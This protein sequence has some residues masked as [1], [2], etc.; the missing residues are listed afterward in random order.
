[1]AGNDRKGTPR[2]TE[3]DEFTRRRE[4]GRSA[5]CRDQAANARE[6]DGSLERSRDQER[7]ERDEMVER[8]EEKTGRRR[9]Q[10]PRGGGLAAGERL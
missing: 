5:C 8:A 3:G 10:K 7:K 4:K 2:T 6:A 9:G 1:M